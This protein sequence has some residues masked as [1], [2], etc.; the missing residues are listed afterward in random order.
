MK[1]INT[2]HQWLRFEIDFSILK[3]HRSAKSPTPHGLCKHCLNLA[4]ERF[5]H[6]CVNQPLVNV[7][8]HLEL[9]SVL[10]FED[11]DVADD[12]IVVERQRPSI[13]VYRTFFSSPDW[14]E[15]V[16]VFDPR[17]RSHNHNNS[18]FSWQFMNWPDKLE[19]LSLA[20]LSRLMQCNTIAYWAYCKL[21]RKWSVLKM[22]PSSYLFMCNQARLVACPLNWASA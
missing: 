2:W 21:W 18:S 7:C 13:W 3:S 12:G 10:I 1:P 15:K 14:H 17:S 11:C 4:T 5:E 9:S 6:L 19:C 20:N 22:V 8:D 16:M